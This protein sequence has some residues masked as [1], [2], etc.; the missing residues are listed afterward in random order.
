MYSVGAASDIQMASSEMSTSLF[1][2]TEEA[3]Y[4]KRLAALLANWHCGQSALYFLD[5]VFSSSYE[6]RIQLWIL[7]QNQ[8]WAQYHQL[9]TRLC[10]PHKLLVGWRLE[11]GENYSN[12]LGLPEHE[13]HKQAG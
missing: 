2:G 1:C 5:V 8:Y 7:V 3:R 4:H 6:I 9:E 12:Q 13:E 10:S 11:T